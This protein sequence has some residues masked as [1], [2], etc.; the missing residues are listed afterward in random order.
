EAFTQ[1]TEAVRRGG[2]ALGEGSVGAAN[3]EWVT[4]AR[5]M[6]PLARIPAQMMAAELRKG[7]EAHRVLDIAA[8][9]GMYGISVAKE[10]PGAQVYAAD[11]QNGLEGG[12][13]NEK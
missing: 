7:G 1:L 9:H 3:P 11:R 12:A 6:M 13:G 8:G 5:A 4:F 2:T 10:N